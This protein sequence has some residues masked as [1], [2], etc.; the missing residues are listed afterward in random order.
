MFIKSK[1]ISLSSGHHIQIQPGMRLCPH[2]SM[3]ATAYRQASCG[4]PTCARMS[5]ESLPTA[6][7]RTHLAG[8]PPGLA[9]RL[10]TP[11]SKTELPCVASRPNKA[12]QTSGSA[13]SALTCS[14]PSPP[15]PRSGSTRQRKANRSCQALHPF[16]TQ[17]LHVSSSCKKQW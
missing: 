12:E 16:N 5:L 13:F 15:A 7:G 10:H 3:A 11:R 1:R 2:V 8:K 17:C 9:P 4:P 6:A 14:P